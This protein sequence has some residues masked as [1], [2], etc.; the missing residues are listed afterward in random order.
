MTYR[1]VR[2]VARSARRGDRDFVRD[3]LESLARIPV[4]TVRDLAGPNLRECNI[5]GWTGRNFY[6]N[7]GPGYHEH[8][9]ACPGCSG[10]DRHRSLLALLVATT[11]IF[12]PGTRILEVAPMRGFESLLRS[13]P[14]IDYTSFDLARHAME[15]GDITAMRHPDSSADYFICFH[16]LEHIPDE[17]LALAEIHRVL[18]PGGVA[19]LQ[20]PVDWHVAATREYPAPD[21]RDVGHVRR[22]G[23]DF[24]ERIAAA[25]FDVTGRSVL[26]VFTPDTVSRFGMSPEPIFFASCV[27]HD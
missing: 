7:T 4:L 6:P 9:T 18:K 12:D 23:A 22:H 16:V 2:H 5:C 11:T 13:Q 14:G 21:P 15:R 27:P 25:G 10:Q 17:H 19:V 24:A 26:D 3:G 20:V 1:L 8:A